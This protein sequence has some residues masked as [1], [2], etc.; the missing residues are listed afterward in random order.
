MYSFS[1]KVIKGEGRGRTL[2]FPTANLDNKSLPL[3]HGVYL[4]EVKLGK[5]KYQ[6]LLHFGSKKTFNNKVAVEI[7]IKDF[8][9]DIY[10]QRLTVSVKKKLRPIKKFENRNA[11]IKQIKLD[12]AAFGDKL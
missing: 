1:G 12:L 4:V 8:N 3:N 7:Y 5:E 6:G 9:S 10:G 11:L 2:G